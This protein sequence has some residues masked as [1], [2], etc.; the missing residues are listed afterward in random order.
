MHQQWMHTDDK[1]TVTD[2]VA[3]MIHKTGE[4]ITI[5]RFVTFELGE[6]LEKRSDNFA[7]E[8]AQMTGSN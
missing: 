5:R 8:V 3:S 7:D 1:M 6:G 4:N 2:V